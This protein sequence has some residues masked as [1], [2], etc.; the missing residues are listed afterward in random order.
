MIKSKRFAVP[1]PQKVH[2]RRQIR[3]SGR[4]LKHAI[5][6]FSSIIVLGTFMLLGSIVIEQRD[7]AEE[8]AWND[9][10]NLSG[11]FEEQIR[12]VMNGIR[13]AMALLEPHLLREGSSFNFAGWTQ[14]IPEFAEPTVQV[15]FTGPDGKLIASS[16]DKKARGLDLSDREHIR[17]QLSGQ[18]G[19]LFIG[20]PVVGRISG[21]TT[22]QVT[23][24]VESPGGELL[25][26]MVFSLSP[27]FLT[28]LH[29]SVNLGKTG[30]M[31]LAGT[32]GIIRASFAGNERVAGSDPGNSIESAEPIAAARSS[33]SGTYEA[34][35]PVN[36][37]DTFFHWRKVTGYPLIV[38]VGIGKDE[39]F[40]PVRATAGLLAGLGACVFIITLSAALILNREI[41]RRVN[42]EIAL[43]NESRKLIHAN[44]DLQ[45]RHKE[46]L[47]TSAE[48]NAERERLNA[49]NAKLAAAMERADQAN[50]AKT[51]LLMNMSHEFRTPMHAI[52]NY[53]SMGLKKVDDAD[54]G[55]LRK[56][57]SNIQTSGARLLKMLNALLDLAKL[58]SGKF[59]LKTSRADLMQIVLQCQSELEPLSR[60]KDLSVEVE[61]DTRNTSAIFDSEK[62]L[63]VLTN[64]LSNAIKFSPQGGRIKIKIADGCLPVHGKALHCIVSDD[65]IGIPTAE[66]DRIF[67]KFT[68]SS[69]TDHGAGG[70][71]IGLAICRE[72]INLHGGRIWAA[73]AACGGTAIHFMLP[74][75]PKD[76]SAEAPA[77]QGDLNNQMA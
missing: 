16:L 65:G 27:E 48:L 75:Q 10:A 13:G 3:R 28:T 39:V 63:Q 11:A 77:E 40:A 33:N 29:N 71:G 56:Y 61:C 52:L 19:G 23:D 32:D 49:V 58:E 42:R 57:F 73:S 55:K 67:D 36:G 64:L 68:Q 45:R 25:G 66:L 26:V 74:V 35:S 70:S 76:A 9:A 14:H 54:G 43:F 1:H 31:I 12:R 5:A 59:E 47:A 18:A 41:S 37:K 69:K 50:Q 62:T 15:S 44:S 20:K 72:V 38:M 7:Y 2:S 21:Q 60:A 34:R 24:R 8:R 51:S 17:V 6:A 4:K 22:I 46:L 30:S 53:A